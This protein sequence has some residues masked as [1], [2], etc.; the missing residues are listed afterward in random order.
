MAYGHALQNYSQ[1]LSY[2]A[3][4]HGLRLIRSQSASTWSWLNAPPQ[5]SNCHRA[6]LNWL[7]YCWP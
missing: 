1:F 6:R 4:K 3:F 5:T 2:Q 7:R